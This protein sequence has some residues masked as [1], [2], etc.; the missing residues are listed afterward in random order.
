MTCANRRPQQK[1]SDLA[2]VI[3]VRLYD[4]TFP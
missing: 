2:T 3:S 1:A 4:V